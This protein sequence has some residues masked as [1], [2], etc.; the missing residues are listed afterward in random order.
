MKLPKICQ[1]RFLVPPSAL[2]V[3]RNKNDLTSP[4]VGQKTGAAHNLVH[5]LLYTIQVRYGT[6]GRYQLKNSNT[7]VLKSRFG[8]ATLLLQQFQWKTNRNFIKCNSVFYNWLLRYRY[9][10]VITCRIDHMHWL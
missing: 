3:G 5:L 9:Y 2:T 6:G 10:P 7:N 8:S 1:D 4:T